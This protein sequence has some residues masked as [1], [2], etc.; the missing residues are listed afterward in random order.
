MFPKQQRE[1]LIP[2]KTDKWTQSSH[3][4][5]LCSA[6][7]R[8]WEKTERIGGSADVQQ[9]ERRRRRSRPARSN[10]MRQSTEDMNSHCRPRHCHSAATHPLGFHTEHRL[11]RRFNKTTQAAIFQLM[12]PADPFHTWAAAA[13]FL[14]TYSKGPSA[15]TS[16]DR[17]TLSLGERANRPRRPA[18]LKSASRFLLLVVE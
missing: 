2:I 8:L 7:N 18:L 5:P 17:W 10:F 6:V 15:L 13:H 16:W 11:K 14:F 4:P 3:Q 1:V 12:A 9:P